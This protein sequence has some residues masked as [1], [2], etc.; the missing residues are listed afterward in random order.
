MYDIGPPRPH[1]PPQPP[2]HTDIPPPAPSQGHDL[3]TGGGQP[4]RE[5]VPLLQEDDT[6]F[7][8]ARVEA[9]G[10]LDEL[11]LRAGP[12]QVVDDVQDPRSSIRASHVEDQ[13]RAVAG[14]ET[15]GAGIA[16][17]SRAESHSSSTTSVKSLRE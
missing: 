3:D 4:V 7:E 17:R 9:E 6:A 16:P 2:G 8:A 12:G 13:A 1:D 5:V 14:A 15:A 11:R 10:K